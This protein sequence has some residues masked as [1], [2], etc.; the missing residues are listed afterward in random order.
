M[1]APRIRT[2]CACAL[3]FALAAGNGCG[4]DTAAIAQALPP[5]VPRVAVGEPA[6]DFTATDADGKTF[7]LSSFR[8]SPVLLKFFRGHW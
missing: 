1:T 3:A 5:D 2:L 8:G 6:I 7:T 4:R